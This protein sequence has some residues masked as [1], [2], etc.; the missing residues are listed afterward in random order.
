M[1]V[2]AAAHA[3]GLVFTVGLALLLGGS[4]TA[5]DLAWGAA[6]G[7]GSAV[8]LVAIYHGY[9]HYRVGIVAPVVGVLSTACPVAVSAAQGD[10]FSPRV[11]LGI[12][13]GFLAIGM[14]SMSGDKGSGQVARS[15]G[16]GLI[17]AA[18]LGFLLVAFAQ[19]S[20]DGG[21]WIVA[22]S[23]L[24]GLVIL[25]ALMAITGAKPHVGRSNVAVIIAIAVLSSSANALYATA[26]TL[27]SLATVA[28][29]ASMFPAVSVALAW[30]VFRER[31]GRLQMVGFALAI[32]SVGL[33]AL[34]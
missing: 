15:I 12:A 29:V 9:A 27:G 13:L 24:S 4:P 6:A 31:I 3:A 28:V 19:T 10:S 17:G 30:L 22:P 32:A 14:V 18:G 1:V 34:G 33:I 2:S 23:R 25:A 21:V 11:G 16:F 5:S 20:D 26:T 8:G 7:A